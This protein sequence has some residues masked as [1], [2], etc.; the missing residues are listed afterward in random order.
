M[1][2][3]GLDFIQPLRVESNLSQLLIDRKYVGIDRK[4]PQK[5]AKDLVT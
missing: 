1:I 4:Y 2:T 5:S 3:R